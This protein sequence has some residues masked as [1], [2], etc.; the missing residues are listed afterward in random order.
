MKPIFA[1]IAVELPV[2]QT[3]TYAVP[4]EL[5]HLAS[6]GKRALVPFGRRT[7]TGYIL[8]LTDSAGEVSGIK[9]ILDVI[10]SEPIFDEKRLKFFKWLSSYYFAP[11]GEALSLIHPA[12]TNIKSRRHFEI[13]EAGEGSVHGKKGL[14]QEI[15]K[16]VSKGA[17]LS[18]LLKTFRG[19]PVHSAVERLKKEGLL[20][21]EALLKGGGPEKTERFV[22]VKG[23]TALPHLLKRSPIQARVYEYLIKNGESSSSAI[24]KDLG[25]VAEA[26]KR[27]AEKGFV[28]VA[29][30][31]VLR[32]PISEIVPRAE[33]HEP[34]TEQQAAINQISES[35]KKN[36]FSPFLLYGVTGSGKTLVYLKI[37]AEVIRSGKKAVILAPE[38]ALTPWPA[39]YLAALFPG[40]IALAHSGLSPG[41]R[42]DE[43]GRILRGEADIVVGARSALFSPVKDLGLIIVDEEHESS[44]KQEDGIKYNARDSALMLGKYLGI[45]VV[46]GSATPSVETFYNALTGKITPI[47]LRNRVNKQILP[48]IEILDMKG[49]K[50]VISERLKSLMGDAFAEGHQ[51]LL[52][53]NRR[54][55]SNSVICRDCGQTFKC[56]NCSVSLTM[57]KRGNVLKCH[58]CDLSI[59]IPEA[60]PTCKGVDLAAPGTGTEKVEEEVRS[61]FPGIRV[62]R[63]DRDTTRKKGSAKRIIDAVED[64]K[65]DVLI[66]T[67]MVSKGHHFPGITLAGVISG[68]TSLNIPDFR[69]SE[70]TFQL[71][72][73]AAGRAGRGDVAGTVVIQTLNPLHYC[74]KNALT[75][76][77]DGFYKEEIELRE[78]TSYPPFT[79]VCNLRI[80]GSKE[81]RVIQAACELKGIAEGI[82]SRKGYC[83]TIL[84]PAPSPLKMIRGQHR[85]QMLIKGGELKTL[86]TFLKGLKTAFDSKKRSGVTLTID[87]DPLN[88][89]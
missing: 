10:D 72:T 5:K 42:L 21:E 79:R 65:V 36:T 28:D 73:Q 1:E 4:G 50:A 44:Y 24:R 77:Y 6:V 41:E 67:Q 37:L 40:R 43:W 86:H 33:N 8:S 47:Y 19:K 2:E 26:V 87:M 18:T 25:N 22:K 16:A 29:E 56:L 83:V 9:P 75:H 27:L 70:R 32:N 39:A 82:V 74:F 80:E 81:D 13:T 53:L 48:K 61:L 15:L 45:T 3:F 76:D 58:Y 59:P 14:E 69:S 55:F 17:A 71:I 23:G 52:F 54:G 11:I 30:R 51:A 12:G 85:W 38:I 62:G 20:T 31:Q 88:I 49:D 57:H 84:G 46:L 35:L 60:C 63:M 64:R 89:I 68:D 78:E 7:L 66:G 34:N